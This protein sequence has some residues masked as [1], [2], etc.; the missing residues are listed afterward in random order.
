M[1]IVEIYLLLQIKRK[2]IHNKKYVD[3]NIKFGLYTVKQWFMGVI[4]N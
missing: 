4:P 3:F 2:M 1:E